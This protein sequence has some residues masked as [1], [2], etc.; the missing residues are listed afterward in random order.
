[1]SFLR[2]SRTVLTFSAT[3]IIALPVKRSVSSAETGCSVNVAPVGY[4]SEK[5]LSFSPFIHSISYGN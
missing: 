1:M 3:T 2:I 4:E 5:K